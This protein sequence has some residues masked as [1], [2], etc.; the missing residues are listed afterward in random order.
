MKC[1]Y[2]GK[3]DED[4]IWVKIPELNIEVEKDVHD[5]N[6]SWNDLELNSREKELLT[7]EQAIWLS[8]SKY[9]KELKLDGSSNQDDFFI[10]QPF[11]LNRKNGLV[12]RLDA[13]SGRAYLA[14]LRL[15]EDSASSFGVR[16]CRTLKV[17]N[18]K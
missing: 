16:F 5:K 11:K 17:K 6:K 3:D 18:G 4:N 2:C 10:Q 12:A 14:C 13:N 7:A 9:A 8:N 1:K 15:P